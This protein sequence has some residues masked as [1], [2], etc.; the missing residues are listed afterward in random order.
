[1][2]ATYTFPEGGFYPPFQLR[3]YMNRY[4]LVS[5]HASCVFFCGHCGEVYGSRKVQGR[6]WHSYRGCCLQ[7]PPMFRE[8]PGSVYEPRLFEDASYELLL[9][10]FLLHYNH[11]FKDSQ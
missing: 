1:M 10:E 8:I 3:P 2:Y 11:H 7:C 6:D 4:Q 5:K 9:R